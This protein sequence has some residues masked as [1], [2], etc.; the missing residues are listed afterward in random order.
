[1]NP[2]PA[3]IPSVVAP[4]CALLR[5]GRHRSF[6]SLIPQ[7]LRRRTVGCDSGNVLV[8]AG[9]DWETAAGKAEGDFGERPHHTYL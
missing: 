1:M 6:G 7:V 4:M 8:Q 3:L 9:E 2:L 5:S